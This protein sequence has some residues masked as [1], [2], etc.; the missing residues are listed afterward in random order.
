MTVGI[1]AELAADMAEE[2]EMHEYTIEERLA[3]LEGKSEHWAMLE[4]RLP[5]LEDIVIKQ[6][7]QMERL[8]ATVDGL[9]EQLN[10]VQ[11]VVDEAQ[12]KCATLMRA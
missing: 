3:W 9:T 7:E 11:N 12:D 1:R 6:A 10:F 2:G 8:A 4:E 5:K